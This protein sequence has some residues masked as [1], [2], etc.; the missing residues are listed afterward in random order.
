M[1]A[2]G[3]G[4][5]AIAGAMGM[6]VSVPGQHT[7]YYEAKARTGC[8]LE[9]VRAY[10]DYKLGP[11][12]GR[13]SAPT[14]TWSHYCCARL[15]SPGL[16]APGSWAPAEFGYHLT[17]AAC[18][19]LAVVAHSDSQPIVVSVGRLTTANELAELT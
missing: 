9:T 2:I 18:A 6:G 1:S 5:G 13:T 16:P 15:L 3:A 4:V 19:V 7:R 14:P 8:R 17:A 12:R 11:G 10:A